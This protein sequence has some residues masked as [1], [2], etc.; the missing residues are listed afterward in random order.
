[1]QKINQILNKTIKTKQLKMLYF[2]PA[3]NLD[4]K[5]N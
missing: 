5:Y 1:M 4:N 3:T 2:Y